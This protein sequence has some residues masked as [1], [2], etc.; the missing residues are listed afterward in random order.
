[1]DRRFKMFKKILNLHSWY[2]P[3]VPPLGIHPRE[4]EV[5][6]TVALF[7]ISSSWNPKCHSFMWWMN[8]HLPW[9][10]VNSKKKLIQHGQIS[11]AFFVVRRSHTQQEIFYFH[12]VLPDI[13]EKV[14]LCGNKTD[15]WLLGVGDGGVL[16]EKS[17]WELWG[18][19]EIYNFDYGCG[20]TTLSECI[21]LCT[22]CRHF[23]R[24]PNG[25]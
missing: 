12:I 19:T 15:Q 8:H 11:Q 6:S 7:A 2:D 17:T 4:W 3:A 20:S 1:M 10:T 24:S 18:M 13:L 5:T 22:L 21:H 9:N 14:E 25:Q 16:A 23:T